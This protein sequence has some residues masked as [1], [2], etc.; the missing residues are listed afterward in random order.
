MERQW[1]SQKGI[2]FSNG[3]MTS[4]TLS[5]QVIPWPAQ[6]CPMPHTVLVTVLGPVSVKEKMFS[7][8]L[9]SLSGYS[10]GPSNGWGATVLP[11]AASW[12]LKQPTTVQHYNVP[13]TVESGSLLSLCHACVKWRWTGESGSTSQCPNSRWSSQSPTSVD[14]ALQVEIVQSDP[15]QTKVKV[16]LFKVSVK[17]IKASCWWL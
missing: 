5:S 13:S 17:T 4:T 7:A 12:W 14:R 1:L 16:T 8:L 2:Y 10:R 6:M 15:M 9:E 11:E 3:P